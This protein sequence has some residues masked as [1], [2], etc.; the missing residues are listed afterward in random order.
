MTDTPIA[1]ITAAIPFW[2]SLLLIPLAIYA[3]MTGGW[4]V[5]LLPIC[6]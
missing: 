3:A 5:L 4:A 6:T 1:K 2:M